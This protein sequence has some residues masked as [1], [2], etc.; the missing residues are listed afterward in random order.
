[1][2]HIMQGCPVMTFCK[3]GIQCLRL[4]DNEAASWLKVMVI[5]AFVK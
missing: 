2:A 4:A 3:G 5:T 1:M